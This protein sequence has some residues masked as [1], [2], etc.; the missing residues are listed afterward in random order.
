MST[1]LLTRCRHNES[2]CLM[3]SERYMT[4]GREERVLTVW[5]ANFHV[6]SPFT[7]ECSKQAN[8]QNN[9]VAAVF[10]TRPHYATVRLHLIFGVWTTDRSFVHHW[11]IE[12]NARQRLGYEHQQRDHP[13]ELKPE[14]L[15]P[16]RSEDSNS[17]AHSTTTNNDVQALAF[18]QAFAS[19]WYKTTMIT[20]HWAW[21]QAGHQRYRFATPTAIASPSPVNTWTGPN[22]LPQILPFGD[23]HF[24]TISTHMHCTHTCSAHLYTPAF[25]WSIHMCYSATLTH[26]PQNQPPENPSHFHSRHSTLTSPLT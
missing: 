11:T 1:F 4:R 24:H 14:T 23:S 2:V 12:L 7:Y 3:Y 6:C 15:T 22:F 5:G 19:L 20:P 10:H 16:I 25:S 8:K 21:E 26:P 13:L 9:K 18:A 17:M